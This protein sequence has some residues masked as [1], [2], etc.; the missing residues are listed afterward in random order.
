MAAACS[1]SSHGLHA[2]VLHDKRLASSLAF[3]FFLSNDNGFCRHK[4]FSRHI[5]RE[6]TIVI[7][8]THV[9][10]H[11]LTESINSHFFMRIY[12]FAVPSATAS[13][14]QPKSQKKKQLRIAYRT[15]GMRY[16]IITNYFHIHLCK[17][18]RNGATNM[19]LLRAQRQAPLIHSAETQTRKKEY[20]YYY[21]N[22]LLLLYHCCWHLAVLG[23][24]WTS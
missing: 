4:I 19:R 3:D 8:R 23:C 13:P 14:N 22:C 1:F 16:V 2:T 7:V 6:A 18:Y 20:I 10:R 24:R 5:R 11:R 12:S 21:Y 9:M 15:L 17:L